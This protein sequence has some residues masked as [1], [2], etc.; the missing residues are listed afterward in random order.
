MTK[1]F[2]QVALKKEAALDNATSF[3]NINMFFQNYF[4]KKS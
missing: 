2:L 3:H 4:L 1:A